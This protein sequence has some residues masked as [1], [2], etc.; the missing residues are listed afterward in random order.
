MNNKIQKYVIRS[1]LALYI[2]SRTNT[3]T[4]TLKSQK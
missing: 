3:E 2:F 4:V 1:E